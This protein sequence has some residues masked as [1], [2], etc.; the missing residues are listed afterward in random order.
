M[1]GV[2]AMF[3]VM[4]Q[5]IISA[6]NNVR[7]I[8]ATFQDIRANGYNLENIIVLSPYGQGSI[9]VTNIRGM[10]VA[11]Q[12]SNKNAYYCVGYSN[13]LPPNTAY[14][15]ANGESWSFSQ[16]YVLAYQ[17]TGIAAYR[18][19]DNAYSATLAS[20]EWIEKIFKDIIA[21]NNTTL[22]N[23]I[24]DVI[25]P[26]FAGLGVTIAP[27]PANAILTSDNSA[28]NDGEILITDTGTVP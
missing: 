21:D 16:K 12:E 2:T 13:C 5:A 15:P 26:A 19:E 27:I 24:N 14:S 4:K 10:L 25:V 11:D 17:N 7:F 18:V 20:G 22:R 23:Y 8:T 6:Y 3:V 9:P 1:M 28:I